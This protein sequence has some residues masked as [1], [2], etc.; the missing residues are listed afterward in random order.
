MINNLIISIRDYDNLVNA[1]VDNNYR[2]LPYEFDYQLRYLQQ[3]LTNPA[4]NCKEL[5]KASFSKDSN[6]K[7]AINLSFSHRGIT[8]DKLQK[9]SEN[10]RLVTYLIKDLYSGVYNPY[11]WDLLTYLL[12]KGFNCPNFSFTDRGLIVGFLQTDAKGRFNKGQVNLKGDNY[13]LETEDLVVF[14][15]EPI[16]HLS[17]E[18]MVFIPAM[19]ITKWV[20]KKITAS[21]AK[22]VGLTYLD[23]KSLSLKEKINKVTTDADADIIKVPY[24]LDS[25]YYT[26]WSTDD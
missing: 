11:I 24:N 19:S 5:L 6:F 20:G 2:V 12:S 15:T 16:T 22:V 21:E 23:T 7:Q 10:S 3:L 18:Y 17:R 9:I 8:V 1:F 25:N 26:F 4:Y 14:S 13:T